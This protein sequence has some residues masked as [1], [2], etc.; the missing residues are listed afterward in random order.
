V[1]V[2]MT[3]RGMMCEWFTCKVNSSRERGCLVSTGNGR[4]HL[5]NEIQ[6]MGEMYVKEKA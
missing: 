6:K 5:E 3:G 2:C 4:R 1:L